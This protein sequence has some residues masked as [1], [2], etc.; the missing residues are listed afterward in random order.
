MRR[1]VVGLACD[2]IFLRR[3]FRGLF[4]RILRFLVVGHL[5]ISI[6]DA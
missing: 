6:L 2:L 3:L 5:H 4:L 1:A